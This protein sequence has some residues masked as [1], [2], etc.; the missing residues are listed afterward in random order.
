[1]MSKHLLHRSLL[2]TWLSFLVRAMPSAFSCSTSFFNSV[3]P[4][5]GKVITAL[6]A[7]VVGNYSDEIDGESNNWLIGNITGLNFC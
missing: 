3:A 4:P 7:A 1:M 5:P 2:L 6:E